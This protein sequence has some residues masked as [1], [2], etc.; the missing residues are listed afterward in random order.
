MK[1]PRP[2]GR[3]IGSILVAGALAF[4][5]AGKAEATPLQSYDPAV[6][7]YVLMQPDYSNVHVLDN[8]DGVQ[9]P[10]AE[11]FAVAKPDGGVFDEQGNPIDDDSK[12]DAGFRL[13]F[14][15][16]DG[17]VCGMYDPQGRGLY[18]F[19]DLP[20]Y[21]DGIYGDD[22]SSGDL[23]E[24]FV[25]NEPVTILARDFDTG[26]YFDAFFSTGDLA[27]G[28]TQCYDE[29]NHITITDTVVP[30]PSTVALLGAGLAGLAGLGRRKRN[31]GV[32]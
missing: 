12:T 9:E 4:G 2:I 27:S 16:Q 18:D 19:V 21:G 29:E 7:N 1:P 24:G 10:P 3:W 6:P 31:G 22:L 23:D 25:P 15:G 14:V 28:F 17:Q 30:E 8:Y 32:V 13:W 5:S 11:Y 20:Q 26:Q